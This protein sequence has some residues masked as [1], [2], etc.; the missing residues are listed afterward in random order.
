MCAAMFICYLMCCRCAS[1]LQTDIGLSLFP[2]ECEL[3]GSLDI[4][5]CRTNVL[6]FVSLI[7]RRL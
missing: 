6:M 7:R 4:L 1:S 2:S 3:G 5:T